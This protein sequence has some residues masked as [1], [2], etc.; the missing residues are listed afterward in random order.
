M[1]TKEELLR[2][3]QA[4]L[5]DHKL[6]VVSNR[7]PYVHKKE[8]GAIQVQQPASGM[9]AAIDPILKACGGTWIAHGA[10]N[11]DRETVDEHGHVAVPPGDPKYTLRRVWLT[12]Q[13]EQDYYYGC[14]N[15]CLWPLCHVVYI[16]P[17]FKDKYWEA[18]REVNRLFA[19][20]VL[21]EAGDGPAFVFIQD[22]HFALLPRMLKERNPNLTIAQFWHIPWPT[23]EIFRTLP[24]GEE[25]LDGL[26]GNDLLGFHLRYNSRNFSESVRLGIEAR[27]DQTGF[28]IT[29]RGHVTRIRAFPISVDFDEQST[30]A[31]TE[32]VKREQD[33]WTRELNL[34][35][36]ILGIGIERSDYTKGIPER[37]RAIDRMLELWPEYRG[38]LL[39]VQIA[40][41]SRAQIDDYQRLDEEITHLAAKINE[42]W[43]QDGVAPVVLIKEQHS[44]VSMAALHRVAHFC[45]V[46]AL[47]DGMNLVAKEFAASRTDE[48]GVLILSRFTGAA[49]ELT[50]ALIVNPFAVGEIAAAC[51]EAVQMPREERR[52]RMQKMRSQIA[53]NNIYRW[54]S[55]LLA[56]LK[57]VE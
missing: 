15:E 43:T 32:E 50:D 42:R 41:P 51:H 40:V 48:D 16:R 3:V 54:A 46:S 34:E 29:R 22:Y 12:E 57:T 9:A 25:M 4:E 19:D 38:R 5:S 13:Q 24:W 28:D 45:V 27:A 39:F 6:I 49:R 44:S 53:R 37:L 35:G 23:Q 8:N 30:L 33:R 11:A 52:R 17:I 1:W 55:E 47:H 20:A 14:S 2:Q 7:E 26:L 56:A 31:G 10:G 18:Y 21:E 36:K